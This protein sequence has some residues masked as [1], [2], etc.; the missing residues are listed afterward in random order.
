MSNQ[1][2]S[3]C[4][5]EITFSTIIDNGKVFCCHGCQTVFQILDLRNEILESKEHPLFIEALKNGIISNP[6]LLQ[7]LENKTKSNPVS[8]TK[9]HYFEI[10]EMWCYSCS[11]LIKLV[12]LKQKGIHSCKID[13]Y[14][15]LATVKFDPKAISKED[16]YKTIENLGY[17]ASPLTDFLEEKKN[18]SLKLRLSIAFFCSL[19]I[20][21]FS[22]PIYASLFF[23]ENE[24][25]TY[26]LAVLA[27]IASLPLVSW[28]FWPVL[29]KAFNGIK[30][31]FLGMESLIVLG[32]VSAFFLSII[33]LL[34]GKSEIYFDSMSS[35]ITLVLLGKVFENKA[36]FSS[37]NTFLKLLRSTPKKARKRFEDG[38]Y[39]IVPIKE[40]SVG[41]LLMAVTGEKI[42]L[43]GE[44]LSG[45][46]ICDESFMTGEPIPCQ[47]KKGDPLMGGSILQHGTINY[48]V[49]ST[50]EETLLHKIF[51]SIHNDMD[52]KANYSRII[53]GIVRYFVPSILVISIVAGTFTYLFTNE[54][55]FSEVIIKIISILLISCPCAL[56]IAAPLAES[57][58]IKKI[59]QLG[60]LV[61]NRAALA[62]LA[63][64]THF[65][66]D[67]TGTITEGKFKILSDLE[68]IR[69]EDLSI[70][71]AMTASSTHP[72]SIT[73]HQEIQLSATT[74]DKVEEFSGKGIKAYKENE[75]F[76]FGSKKFLEQ[77]GFSFLEKNNVSSRLTTE[78][79]FGK[80]NDFVHA[81][82]LG[83]EIKEDSKEFIKKLYPIYTFLISGDS[84]KCVSEV[85]KKCL[86]NKY[87]AE[88]MPLE[89]REIIENYKKNGAIIAM[90][91]DGIN[92]APALTA[93]HV[94]FSVISASDISIHV[95]DIFLTT[96]NLTIIPEMI[97]LAKKGQKIIKQNLFWAFFY[98]IVGISLAIFGFLTPFYAAFAMVMSSTI[99]IFNARRLSRSS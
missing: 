77:E 71:K 31:G 81:I 97:N 30:V 26:L 16:I 92:D 91:G 23:K 53:D 21:M 36:K 98:N 66:I 70:L 42:V 12:L 89:K 55:S 5:L 83:D 3:L 88:I 99:V 51:D 85:S 6:I 47:K 25:Y 69:K 10:Q 45:E 14:T 59:A 95:S 50:F 18:S 17:K 41:D 87:Y 93:A 60:G 19:N 34:K 96:K 80:K 13:Y 73:I 28:C 2:C 8:D 24:S 38:N 27:L 74:L 75:I 57:Y 56:G 33:N 32:V 48:K 63:K 64:I 22:Y 39:K 7:E 15:D 1:Q 44:V 84:K 54:S 76:L 37:K 79:F 82:F 61:K 29:R 90:L 72:I 4:G 43:D 9:E 35:I 58:L 65:F 94:G 52:H 86:F 68:K 20:M 11:E 49:T 78:V 40:I 67:K 62:R 46:G